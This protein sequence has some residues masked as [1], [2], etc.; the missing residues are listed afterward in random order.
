MSLSWIVSV[1]LT[2]FS[3]TAEKRIRRK[4]S[5]FGPLGRQQTCTFRMQWC[6]ALFS[7]TLMLMSRIVDYI[8]KDCPT[9]SK[10][11]NPKVGTPAVL[12][13]AVRLLL[14]TLNA[15]GH[16]IGWCEIGTFTT[17]YAYFSGYGP[18]TMKL[19]PRFITAGRHYYFLNEW[20]SAH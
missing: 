17:V 4:P 2:R 8:T 13:S 16:S 14:T 10:V 7:M 20:R 15:L 11:V 5:K 18:I 12:K 6:S 19:N 9:R 1:A 3:G